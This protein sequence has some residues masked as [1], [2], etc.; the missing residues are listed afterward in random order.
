MT[1]KT[2]I[3]VGTAAALALVPLSL[4][5]AS[6]LPF[7]MGGVIGSLAP[8]TDIGTSEGSRELRRVWAGLCVALASALVAD[9]VLGTGVCDYARTH[10]GLE[11]LAGLA[12]LVAVFALGRASGHRGFSHSVVALAASTLALRLAYPLL[13]TP[14][15]MGYA[16]HLLLD[17]LNKKDQRLFWPLGRGVSLGACKASGVADALLCLAGFLVCLVLVLLHLDILPGA[18]GS[19]AGLRLR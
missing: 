2:H 6:C 17:L 8:D 7:A 12:T 13:A 16:S 4:P 9:A 5:V 3:M 18:L 10:V 14:F 1:G 19:L 11:Q 15:A